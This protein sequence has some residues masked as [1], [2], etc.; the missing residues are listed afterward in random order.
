M[1]GHNPLR[2]RQV[3]ANSW[4]I[5]DYCDRLNRVAWVVASGK[6]YRVA[7]LDDGT[8]YLDRAA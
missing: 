8:R 1:T 2:N 6:P 7:K 5:D 4:S 3:A